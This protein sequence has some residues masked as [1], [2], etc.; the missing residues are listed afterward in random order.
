MENA[1]VL[2]QIAGDI[3]DYVSDPEDRMWML[4]IKGE[5]GAGKSLFARA[6]LSTICHQERTIV[7]ERN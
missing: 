5:A 7:K 3:T 6:L 4:A 1:D 2:H